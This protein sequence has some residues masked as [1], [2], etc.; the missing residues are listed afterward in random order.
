MQYK[1]GGSPMSEQLNVDSQ[2]VENSFANLERFNNMHKI[3]EEIR[4]ELSL[5]QELIEKRNKK[6]QHKR[7][8]FLD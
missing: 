7:S 6:I 2:G 1:K 4:E 3:I 8:K 5:T